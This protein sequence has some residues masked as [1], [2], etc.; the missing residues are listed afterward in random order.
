MRR[1]AA[2]EARHAA[3]GWAVL[4]WG[5]KR[6][7]APGRRLLRAAF[8]AGLDALARRAPVSAEIARVAGHPG[9]AVHR[10]LARSFAS[11]VDAELRAFAI[12]DDDVLQPPQPVDLQRHDVVRA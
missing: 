11:M 3:L 8:D 9:P 6:L 10:E 1:I 7:D 5:A 4:A 12:L 2:D